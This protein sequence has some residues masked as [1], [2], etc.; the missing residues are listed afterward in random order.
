MPRPALQ[1]KKKEKERKAAGKTATPVS[2]EAK[3]KSAADAQAFLCAVCR[4]TFPVNVRVRPSRAVHATHTTPADVTPPAPQ[5]ALL[6]EHAASRHPK[7]PE[8][9]CFPG[10]AAM[11]DAEAKK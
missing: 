6:A 8:P 7:L 3:A 4:Q 9:Q 5:A 10:L 1:L 11:R 2:K